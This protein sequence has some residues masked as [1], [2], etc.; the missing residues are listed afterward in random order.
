MPPKAARELK[1]HSNIDLAGSIQASLQEEKLP[2]Y[3][4]VFKII[5]YERHNSMS[6]SNR[7]V[8]ACP[9]QPG[10]VSAICISGADCVHR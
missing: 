8:I 10:T 6:K 5:G 9:Y 7:E 2:T 1:I 4:D 3:S